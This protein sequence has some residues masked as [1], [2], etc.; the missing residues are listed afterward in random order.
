MGNT[1]V[2]GSLEV[3][4]SFEHNMRVC[5]NFKP[6]PKGWDQPEKTIRPG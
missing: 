1:R 4:H 6:L 5:N 2:L 3:N